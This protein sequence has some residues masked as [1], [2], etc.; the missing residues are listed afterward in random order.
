M[1]EIKKINRNIEILILITVRV[2]YILF[3]YKQKLVK[4]NK[5]FR[6]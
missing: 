2:F 6:R 1:E 3:I 5:K 4:I